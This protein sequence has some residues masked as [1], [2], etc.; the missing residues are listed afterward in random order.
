MLKKK[1]GLSIL[2]SLT[3][4][5]MHLFCLDQGMSNVEKQRRIKEIDSSL[6]SLKKWHGQYRKKQKT[7][8]TKASRVLFKNSSESRQ[9]KEVAAEAR[10]NALV[11]QDKI[12]FLLSQKEHVLNES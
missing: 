5:N 3:L 6:T 7:Y 10:E 1:I 11:L 9:Y 12:D 2:F 4:L 8:Q